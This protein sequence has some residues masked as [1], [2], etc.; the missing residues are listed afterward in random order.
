MKRI[1]AICIVISLLVS[2]SVASAHA[3]WD[4]ISPM[5]DYYRL[6]NATI[7]INNGSATV[8]GRMEGIHGVTT[9]VTI[10]LYLQQ[11]SNGRWVN[12]DDWLESNEGISCTVSKTVTVPTGYKYR[13]KASCYAY[14]GSN[15]EHIVK[16]SKE[17][18]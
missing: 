4:D 15:Y 1:F 18:Q 2:M 3:L 12:Y 13:A 14:A 9:K 11:Y 8:S 6:A 10:H 7:R 5:A 17:V 16:Y